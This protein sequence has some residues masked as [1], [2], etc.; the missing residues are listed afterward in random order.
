LC[1]D[2][3]AMPG[4]RPYRYAA[5]R[6]RDAQ[7]GVNGHRPLATFSSTQPMIRLD[8]IF[9]SRHF[10]ALA[11]RVLRNDLTRV[12]SDHLPLVADLRVAAAGEERASRTFPES[13]PHKGPVPAAAR[14]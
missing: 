2:F 10:E 3:N 4:S 9:I 5:Q 14:G 12:A 11:A 6:M 13:V 8:H 7:V 1:G